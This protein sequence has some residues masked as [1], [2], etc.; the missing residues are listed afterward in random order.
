MRLALCL[1]TCAT[2]CCQAA[3]VQTLR[4]TPDN[5]RWGYYWAQAAPAIKI[6]SGDR[7]RI[8][9]VSGN[10]TRLL[11]AGAKPDEIQPELKAIYAQIP[12]SERGPGG[13]ILT[14]AV[15]VAEAEPGD[16]LEVRTE[17]ITM[18]VP[19]AYN[20]FSPNG[21][22]M[23][24]DFPNERGMKVFPL[25]RKRNVALFAPGIE[26]PLH[27]FFGSMGIAPPGDAKVDSAPPNVHAGNMDNKE[28]VE[29]STLYI[30]VHQKGAL[31]EVG[32]GHVAMGNGEVDITALETSLSGTFQFIVHKGVSLKW[33]RAETPSEY[34][35][36]GFDQDLTKAT[37]IA[38]REMIDF[39]STEKHL[40]RT[41]A[42]ML[43]SV[44][45]DVD[46]TQLVDGNKGV[47]AMCPKAIFTENKNAPMIAAGN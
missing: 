11:A 40:S 7:L 33:P 26:I 39:L 1:L 13:H 22:F 41:D 45:A 42:Y 16:V 47:H 29:G 20:G 28:L 3:E 23:K 35:T 25:D 12:Q 37:E 4:A 9:T 17:K 8:Q 19:Y 2:L 32:D 36:M 31:F 15:Y 46:I 6:H 30:P 18:D 43:T 10:P 14:G 34:I 5:I 44:A 24:A 27:P 38:V 21:G